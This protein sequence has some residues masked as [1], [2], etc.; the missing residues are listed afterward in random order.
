MF[1]QQCHHLFHYFII[2]WQEKLVIQ[3][4]IHFIV[5]LYVTADKISSC[6]YEM[7]SVRA[8]IAKSAHA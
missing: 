3:M 8:F 1:I 5:T 7:F 4:Q 2:F 6:K